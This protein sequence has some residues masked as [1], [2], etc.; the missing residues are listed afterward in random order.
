[1]AAVDPDATDVLGPLAR[2]VGHRG[3]P[4]GPRGHGRAPFRL[5]GGIDADVEGRPLARMP[6]AQAGGRF[7]TAG[8]RL[9]WHLRQVSHSH[10][11]AGA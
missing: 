9:R 8:T 6:R 1:M 11:C 7:R 5:L 2:R 3:C 10:W 4:F